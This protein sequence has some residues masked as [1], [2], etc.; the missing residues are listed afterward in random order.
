[1]TRILIL[2]LAGIAALVLTGCASAGGQVGERPAELDRLD[3]WIGEWEST[4]EV[5]P[6]GSDKPIKSKGRES[7]SWECGKRFVL[8]RMN[9]EV[10]GSP[11]EEALAVRTW[12]AKGRV[13]R[14]WYFD[15]QGMVGHSRMT[16]DEASQTWTGKTKGHDPTSGE[17]TAGTITIRQ[18]DPDT[19]EWRFEEYDRLMLSKRVEMRGTSRRRR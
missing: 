1:M 8:E 17:P 6:A 10:E 7:L 9:W 4:G 14:S 11:T 18:V 5:L 12:D 3:A 15:N 16:Y 13:Y 19:L 2:V